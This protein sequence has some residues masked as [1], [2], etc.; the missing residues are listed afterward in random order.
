MAQK[1][2]VLAS[3]RGPSPAS[4]PHEVEVGGC[5]AVWQDG[6]SIGSHP[7]CTIVLPELT[8]VA[9]FV[10]A[11]SNHKLLYLL[12]EGTSLPLPRPAFPVGHYDHRIDSREFQLGP[13]WIRFQ[14][15]YRDA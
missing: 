2:F 6:V 12:P 8:P 9:A 3:V 14:E 15:I 5:H 13:Y 11:A 7:N 1:C 10:R 4:L